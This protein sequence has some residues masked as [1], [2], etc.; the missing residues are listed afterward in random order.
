M[1][2]A[3]RRREYRH[4]ALM[5]GAVRFRAR[6]ATLDGIVRNISVGGARLQVANAMWLPEQFELDIRH[7]DI[8]VEARVVWRELG[9]AGISFLPYERRIGLP[10]RAEG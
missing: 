2:A 3:E 6:N 10:A 4:R 8:R 1:Q 7:Q 9:E 5:G